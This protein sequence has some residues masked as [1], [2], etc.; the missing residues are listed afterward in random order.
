MN[1]WTYAA[2]CITGMFSFPILGIMAA[3]TGESIV[4]GRYVDA[5]L[6][7]LCG[8]GLIVILGYLTITFIAEKK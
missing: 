5:L 8:I 2:G 3:I 6:T 4:R 7:D 1:P